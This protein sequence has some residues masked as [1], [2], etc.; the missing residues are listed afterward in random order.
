MTAMPKHAKRSRTERAAGHGHF[1]LLDKAHINQLCAVLGSERLEGLLRLL[2][3]ELT[4]RPVLI[5]GAVLAGDLSRARHE[6]HSFKGA[7]TSVGAMALGQAAEAIE[8]AEDLRAMTAALPALDR[9]VA[10][11]LG[12]LAALLPS[13]SSGAEAR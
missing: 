10:R 3:T 1:P 11:T 2:S 12:A 6:S 9:Q 7:T 5:R 8:H 4:N 13:T